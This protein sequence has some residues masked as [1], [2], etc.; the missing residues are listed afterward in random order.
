MPNMN[1]DITEGGL[2]QGFGQAQKGVS[3]LL[4]QV[5]KATAVCQAG[6][7]CGLAWQVVLTSIAVLC[8][9]RQLKAVAPGHV[10]VQRNESADEAFRNAASAFEVSA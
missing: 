9:C 2:L 1:S 6:V 5:Y 3:A 10:L 8:T 4:Q 7:V